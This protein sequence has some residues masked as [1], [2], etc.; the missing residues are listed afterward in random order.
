MVISRGSIYVSPAWIQVIPN[1]ICQASRNWQATF[2]S[3]LVS[4]G[5]IQSS[6]DHSLFVLSRNN[7]FFALLIYVDDIILASNNPAAT[8]TL[9]H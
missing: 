7:S 2:T 1:P 9:K 4:Y 6:A 5:F 8:R 3:A